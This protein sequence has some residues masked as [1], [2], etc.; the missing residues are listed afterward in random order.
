M[1]RLAGSH[2]DSFIYT[3]MCPIA[4]VGYQGFCVFRHIDFELTF[5]DDYFPFVWKNAEVLRHR[6]MLKRI[7]Q[8]L[9]K[10]PVESKRSEWLI[11]VMPAASLF[12]A[13]ILLLVS[14]GA[15]AQGLM[16]LQV[17]AGVL[18]HDRAIGQRWTRADFEP[19]V[20]GTHTLRVEWNGNANLQFSVFELIEAPGP[21]TRL[22]IGTATRVA[23]TAVEW[24]GELDASSDHYLGIWSASGSASFIASLSAETVSLPTDT[25]RLS[26]VLNYGVA[27]T[28]GIEGSKF[29]QVGFMPKVSGEVTIERDW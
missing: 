25:V 13:S 6:P 17:G 7:T 5:P 9:V 15:A 4:S 28:S 2:S 21:A 1:L 22:K 3:K 19:T 18:D 10:L 29:S 12:W 16:P 8:A 24:T 11:A 23:G 14:L 20:S 27:D 26:D